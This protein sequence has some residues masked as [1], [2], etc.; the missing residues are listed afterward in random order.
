MKLQLKAARKLLPFVPSYSL[1]HR[2]P[3]S[4]GPLKPESENGT[5]TAKPVKKKRKRNPEKKNAEANR[6]QLRE[7]E[8]CPKCQ[9]WVK[10]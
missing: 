4:L 10:C 5:G 8:K 1:T 3:L 6:C 2:S 7:T 9:H